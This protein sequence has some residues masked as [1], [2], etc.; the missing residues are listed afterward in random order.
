MSSTRPSRPT[1]H[2]RRLQAQLERGQGRG[3]FWPAQMGLS[4]DQ[5]AGALRYLFDRPVPAP[6]SS[7]SPWY[8]DVWAEPF[9]ASLTEWVQIQTALFNAAGQD[10]AGYGDEQVGMGLNYLINAAFSSVPSALREGRVPAIDRLRLMCALPWLWAECIGP[11]LAHVHAPV[12]TGAGGT[13]GFV[14]YMW[15]DVWPIPGEDEDDPIW[16]QAL[17]DALDDML[18]VP[19]REV[20]IAALHGVGHQK[21]KMLKHL[22]REVDRR[23]AGFVDSWPADDEDLRSYAACALAGQVQ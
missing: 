19:C 6:G 8:D 22:A 5:Y 12:G 23:V 4:P 16:G 14:C 1:R 11:R 7:E 15:F 9:E 20:Q 10:L 3:R 17:W 13:L 21:H 18:A 2:D